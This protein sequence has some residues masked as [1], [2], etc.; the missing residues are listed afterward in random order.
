ML[1]FI[2]EMFVL[3][4]W[5]GGLID[6]FGARLPLVVGPAIAAVGFGLFGLPGTEGSY[7]VTFFPA[8]AVLGLGMSVAVAPLTTA[9][10][11]AVST[12]R[13]GVA[14]GINNAVSRVGGL[15][16][17]AVFGAVILGVFGRSLDQRL[18]AVALPAPART[19][20]VRQREQ[21]AELPPPAH[22]DPATRQ[23]VKRAIDESYVSGFRVAMA[24]AAGLALASA[25][26]AAR[27]VSPHPGG[28]DPPN[29]NS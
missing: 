19:A 24:L 15:V 27:W 14:S 11:S 6:R 8:I 3:S 28:A 22:V 20:L 17:V 5:A 12:D 25:G 13:A 18:S 23:A 1:P 16:A 9:V 10:M 2:L 7:W 26:V 4:R 21:L 29:E